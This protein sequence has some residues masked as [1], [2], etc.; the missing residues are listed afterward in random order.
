MLIEILVSKPVDEDFD[1][2]ILH[3]LSWGT[4][5]HSALEFKVLSGD[6]LHA[7]ACGAMPSN[8]ESV[9]RV[10]IVC[11]KRISVRQKQIVQPLSA[12]IVDGLRSWSSLYLNLHLAMTLGQRRIR[13]Q[14]RV[15]SEQ[16]LISRLFCVTFFEQC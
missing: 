2:G 10:K 9:K 7:P 15:K 12:P 14:D 4:Q 1:K 6:R 5:C 11:P 3:P 8:S 16:L 13:G